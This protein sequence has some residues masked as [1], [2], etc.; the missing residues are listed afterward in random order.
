MELTETGHRLWE[1]SVETQAEKEA[2]VAEAL[3]D[4]EKRELNAL[5]R[6][7]MHAFHEHHGPATSKAKHVEPT[8]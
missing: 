4:V 2:R 5:L 8:A 6:R 7:L 3:D 1:T